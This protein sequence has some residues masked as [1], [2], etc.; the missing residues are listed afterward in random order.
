MNTWE[1]WCSLRGEQPIPASPTMIARFINE[2]SSL[3]ID[4]IWPAVLEISRSHYVVSLPDPVLS[5]PVSA[6]IE[7]IAPIK[8]PRSWPIAD[9]QRFSILPYDLK[10]II[11]KREADRDKQIRQM[12]NEFARL[13]R[14]N[15][16]GIQTS[17]TAA[18][19]AA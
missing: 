10:L 13:K 5:G 9:Q 19:E 1:K 18:D 3:G 4:R 12:Q 15:A 7:A 8:P 17:S 14:E 16:S 6:A 11:S 2:I